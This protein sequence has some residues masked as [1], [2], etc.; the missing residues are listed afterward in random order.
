[1]AYG[2]YSKISAKSWE[3]Q[4]FLRFFKQKT[5]GTNP[6]AEIVKISVLT[7]TRTHAVDTN[8]LAQLP[9]LRE[10]SLSRRVRGEKVKV[11]KSLRREMGWPTIEERGKGEEQEQWMRA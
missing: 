5:L 8:W 2:L 7:S 11:Q 10:G 3:E 1:M 9:H 6:T 4:I